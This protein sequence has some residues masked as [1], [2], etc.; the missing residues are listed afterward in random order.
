MIKQFV[1]KDVKVSNETMDMLLN[2]C[3]GEIDGSV[4]WCVH[5]STNLTNDSFHVIP[6]S[7]SDLRH[8]TYT[9]S[10]STNWEGCPKLVMS[11]ELQQQELSPGRSSA[12][13]LLMRGLKV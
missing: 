11:E 4:P 3:T 5:A 7:P 2:C 9:L 1:H 8:A 13:Q 10:L 6:E 12:S